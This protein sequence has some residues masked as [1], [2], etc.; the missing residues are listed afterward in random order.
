MP[1]KRMHPHAL[2]LLTGAWKD[3]VV[4]NPPSDALDVGVPRSTS[5][6][7]G[8]GLEDSVHSPEKRVTSY[9]VAQLAGVTQS[10]VSRALRDDRISQATRQRV[11]AAAASLGYVPS[12][13]GRNL[14]TRR[15]NRVAFVVEDLT[16]PF[17]LWLLLHFERSLANAGF[18]AMVVRHTADDASLLEELGA[19]GVDGVALTSLQLHSTLPQ[20]LQKRGIPAVV[21]NRETEMRCLDTCVS[22]NRLGARLVAQRL[23]D[24]GHRR[25]GMITGPGHTSTGRD[26]ATGFRDALAEAGIALHP[27][28]CREVAYTQPAGRQAVLEILES[29]HR[30]TGLFCANDMLAMGALNAATKLGTAVPEELSVIGYDDVAMSAWER[31]DLT[32]VHQDIQGI[33]SRGAELLLDRI[34]GHHGEPRRVIIQPRLVVRTTDGPPRSP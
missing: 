5:A 23:M 13:L 14:A 10:T 2:L 16:N 28:A 33:A 8:A 15:T 17:Y 34:G 7:A 22:D 18:N 31:F 30:P 25:L 11:L 20:A 12:N 26:R 24:L 9:D 19:G 1:R 6:A 27:A 21:I 4:E 32:T 3:C 29:P